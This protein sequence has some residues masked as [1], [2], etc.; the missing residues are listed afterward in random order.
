MFVS[1][2][3]RLFKPL[4]LYEIQ[5][6]LIQLLLA[7]LAQRN[8]T[9]YPVSQIYVPVTAVCHVMGDVDILEPPEFTWPGV[10]VGIC[11]TSMVLGL[12]IVKELDLICH[13]EWLRRD[14]LS[15]HLIRNHGEGIRCSKVCQ[16]QSHLLSVCRFLVQSVTVQVLNSLDIM[17]GTKRWFV[18]ST[19]LT[20]NSK[21][22]IQSSLIPLFSMKQTI[23]F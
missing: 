2:S 19:G 17:Q 6:V 12:R 18:Y 20:S 3:R 15:L 5:L 4:C 21:P 11:H 9:M 16:I 7:Y 8:S 1:L 23:K 22:Y 13:L 10:G 14:K